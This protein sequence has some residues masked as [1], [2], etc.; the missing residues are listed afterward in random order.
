MAPIILPLIR[1]RLDVL[2]FFIPQTSLSTAMLS[3][4]RN[5][6]MEEERDKLKVLEIGIKN[7][8][9]LKMWNELIF[10]AAISME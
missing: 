5:T 8:A 10:I 4:T 9:S 6:F 1:P 7:G 2:P 3:T